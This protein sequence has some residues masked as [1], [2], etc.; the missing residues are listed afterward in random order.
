MAL[1]KFFSLTMYRIVSIWQHEKNSCME[2]VDNE[3][4]YSVSR[5]TEGK[6]VNMRL[7]TIEGMLEMQESWEVIKC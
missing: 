1:A 2:L 5:V 6:V 4:S 7:R 3:A